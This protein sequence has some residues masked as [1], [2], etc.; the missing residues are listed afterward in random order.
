[1]GCGVGVVAG[2]AAGIIAGSTDGATIG[3]EGGS[4]GD[5]AGVDGTGAGFE[6]PTK[7]AA[8]NAMATRA[9]EPRA[10]GK[11][12]TTQRRHLENPRFTFR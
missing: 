5:G 8:Q 4:G 2:E 6:Q 9:Y 12:F 10:S 3:W 7:M 1:M 11:L